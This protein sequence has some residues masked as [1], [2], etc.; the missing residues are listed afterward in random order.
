[1]FH[2]MSGFFVDAFIPKKDLTITTRQKAEKPAFYPHKTDF[3][4]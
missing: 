4:A 2:H 1:M 3:R